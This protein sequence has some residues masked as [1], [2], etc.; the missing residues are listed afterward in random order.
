MLSDPTIAAAN[1]FLTTTY[2]VAHNSRFAVPAASGLDAHTR[3]RPTIDLADVFCL[4]TT[5]QLGNDWVV[6][7][8]NQALQ[9]TPTRAA[10]RHAAPGCRVLVRERADGGLRIVVRDPLTTR[11][12]TLAWTPMAR[13]IL[14]P[15]SG[16]APAPRALPVA[17]VPA[18][19]YTRSGKPLSAKQ[20][21]VRAHWAQQVTVDQQRRAASKA[22]KERRH[23]A[24]QTTASFD[25][26]L[27][28]SSSF[29]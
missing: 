21:A 13:V 10:R 24:A 16:V 7:Y 2:L 26:R 19:G 18:A 1:Q 15:P 3:L 14:R 25:T 5:R 28:V 11:E 9:V 20:L 4:E 17:T 23:A 22:A 27:E 6:R 29:T 12:S 8:A